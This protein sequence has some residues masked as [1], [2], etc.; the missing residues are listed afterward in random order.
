MLM[1]MHQ[2]KVE[3][4]VMQFGYLGLILLVYEGLSLIPTIYYLGSRCFACSDVLMLIE[5]V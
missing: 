5:Y 2:G 4:V 3:D 1:I